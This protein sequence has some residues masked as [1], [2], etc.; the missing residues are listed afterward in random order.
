ALIQQAQYD[1]LA[2]KGRKRGNADVVI[3]PVD[4]HRHMAVLRMAG[5]GYVNVGHDLN[6]RYDSHFRLTRNAQDI[7][8]NSVDTVAHAHLRLLRVEMHVRRAG[9]DCALDDAL[10]QSDHRDSGRV[11][12]DL[13]KTHRFLSGGR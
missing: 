6:A 8:Q 5:L 7:V 2:E 1:A 9:L 11:P 10:N 13:V 12:Y 4:L 3:L